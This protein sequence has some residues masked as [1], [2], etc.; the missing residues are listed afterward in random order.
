VTRLGRFLHKHSAA[1][2]RRKTDI[3]QARLS[4]LNNDETT[5]IYAEEFYLI[6]LAIKA[7]INLMANE[8][9]QD[10]ELLPLDSSHAPNDNDSEKLTNFGQLLKSKLNNP[11]TLSKLTGIKKSRISSLS[12]KQNTGLL[13]YELFL[14]SLA[15]NIT[16]KVA[17]EALYKQ[18]YL[19]SPEEELKMKQDE[20]EK[21][22]ELNK[23]K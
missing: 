6:A 17:W 23:N 18:V 12:N 5:K 8:V 10:C 4:L 15:L 7:D 13:G 9:F 1:E 22:K 11:A 14:I 19:K 2:I 21:R 3:S 16:P 20:S